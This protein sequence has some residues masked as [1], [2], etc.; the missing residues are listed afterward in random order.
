MKDNPKFE[1]KVK[2]PC[3]ES[4]FTIKSFHDS[5]GPFE[6]H[7]EMKCEYCKKGYQLSSVF[8][9]TKRGPSEMYLWTPR[10]I[11]VDLGLAESNLK[12]AQEEVL[13]IAHEMYLEQWILYCCKGKN[14]REIW[15]RVT[16]NGKQDPPFALFQ[17]LISDLDFTE[18]L[19][20]Y[21]NYQNMDYILDKL[22]VNDTILAEM[23]KMVMRRQGAVDKIKNMMWINGVNDSIGVFE[24]KSN[25]INNDRKKRARI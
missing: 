12:K 15:K 21:F 18:F 24:L 19:T 1:Q 10:T 7:W 6:E 5:K 14:K 8:G 3:G 25:G 23:K 22:E 4:Y 11:H 13:N 17:K 9:E 20:N 16:S 2:C